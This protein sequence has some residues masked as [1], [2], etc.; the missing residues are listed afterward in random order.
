MTK[1]HTDLLLLLRAVGTYGLDV[2][3]LLTDLRLQ[4][5]RDLTEPA[6]KQALRDLADRSLVTEFTSVLEVRRWRITAL[7]ESALQEAGA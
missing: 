6:L 5:H 7:G 2:G 4:R 3:T 1:L